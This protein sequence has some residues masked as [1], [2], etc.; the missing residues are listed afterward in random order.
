MALGDYSDVVA[1]PAHPGERLE[2]K[3]RRL[4]CAVLAVAPMLA[5]AQCNPI[6][7]V[8]VGDRLM[9]VGERM[10]TYEKSGARLSIMVSGFC[11]LNPC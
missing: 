4:L 2:I 3:M 10:C 5:A 6:G 7:W 11:P 1:C 8:L 9:S